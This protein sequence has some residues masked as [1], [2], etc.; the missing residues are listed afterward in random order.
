M[1]AHL[2]GWGFEPSQI[3]IPVLLMHGERDLFV[4]VSHSK[5]LASKIPNV[6]TR[7][8]PE[9]ARPAMRSAP[10]GGS[11]DMRRTRLAFARSLSRLP[12]VR[13]NF[14]SSPPLSQF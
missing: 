12:A 10:K 7:F 14:S 11:A 6:E 4:P 9:D 3:R 1:I 8:L 2:S 5:W 13:S